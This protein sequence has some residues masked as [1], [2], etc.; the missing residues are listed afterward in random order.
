M[1]FIS[2]QADIGGLAAQVEAVLDHSSTL[3]AEKGVCFGA[4]VSGNDVEGLFRLDL[5]AHCMEEIKEV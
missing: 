2:W 3:F 5:G 4:A 1:E